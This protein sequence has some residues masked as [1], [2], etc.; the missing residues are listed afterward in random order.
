MAEMILIF[1]GDQVHKQ[2][3]GF[4]GQDCLKKTK[5]IEEALGDADEKSRV[6]K[7][8]FYEEASEQDQ[9]S[10]HGS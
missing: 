3:T 4:T 8:E 5:F 7:S 6:L 1:D 2:T 9:E 10:I